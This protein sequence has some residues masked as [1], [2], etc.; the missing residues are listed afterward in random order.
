MAGRSTGVFFNSIDNSSV[1]GRN[2][3]IMRIASM[4]VLLVD[5]FFLLIKGRTVGM[6]QC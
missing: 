1:L 6:K 3:D 2:L 5:L 4:H